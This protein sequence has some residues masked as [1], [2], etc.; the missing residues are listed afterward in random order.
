MAKAQV[1][2]AQNGQSTNDQSTKWPAQMAYMHN[3]NGRSKAC[4]LR[5]AGARGQPSKCSPTW[6]SPNHL[7][8]YRCTRCIYCHHFAQAVST[9]PEYDTC[10]VRVVMRR[11]VEMLWAHQSNWLA[12]GLEGGAAHLPAS[13]AIT[14]DVATHSPATEAAAAAAAVVITCST[15]M[16]AAASHV[17]APVNTPGSRRRTRTHNLGCTISSMP[18]P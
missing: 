2:K 13:A 3:N 4:V 8:P 10:Y 7:M 12:A 18:S 1:A 16:A 11:L 17:H 15:R 9:P 6:L 5:A 14:K